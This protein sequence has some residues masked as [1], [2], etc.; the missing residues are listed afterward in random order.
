MIHSVFFAANGMTEVGGE[1]PDI[2]ESL[3]FASGIFAAGLL[4]MSR[5]AY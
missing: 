1:M 3:E 4:G 5:R 2:P